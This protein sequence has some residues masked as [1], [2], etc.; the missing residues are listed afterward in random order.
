MAVNKKNYNKNIKVSESVVAQ[1]RKG[2]KASNIAKAN[3]P[4]ASTEFREAVRRFYGKD[5][6]KAMSMAGGKTVKSGPRRVTSSKPSSSSVKPADKPSSAK[7]GS[8]FMSSTVTPESYKMNVGK[9]N[10]TP[11]KRREIASRQGTGD[12]I[13]GGAAQMLV[14][15]TVGFKALK[16]SKA[17]SSVIRGG[18]AMDIIKG[19]KAIAKTVK[20]K[21]TRLQNQA[22]AQ[23]L[24]KA[25]SEAAKRAAA[26]RA[27]N[28]KKKK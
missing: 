3:A 27:K 13:I 6:T 22:E 19:Q 9:D 23:K 28:A 25:R 1:L 10:L 24:A 5:V 16:A 17:A 14:P 26:T 7:K 18:R 21:S 15:G 12:K 2:T 4:G 11:A 8:N 20:G